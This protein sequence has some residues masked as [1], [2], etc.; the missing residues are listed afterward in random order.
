MIGSL[1]PVGAFN[2][3][4]FEPAVSRRAESSGQTEASTGAPAS[5][6]RN[7]KAQLSEA[8]QKRVR[9][10]Q[11]RDREVR[12]HEMAHV[13]AGGA[14]ILRGAQ[15][16]YETGPD[17][18]RYA[19]G[20]DVLI[21]TSPGRT[22]QETVEKAQRIIAAALAPADPSPQDR[23]VAAKATQMAAEARIEIVLQEREAATAPADGRD[24]VTDA[25]Q[26]PDPQP[27]SVFTGQQMTRAYNATGAADAAANLV[28]LFA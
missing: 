5:S 13:A 6:T 10:L 18:V 25:S 4:A 22:P 17:G 1:P 16:E 14:L 26:Q 24:A 2:P 20:G 15:Y 12:A 28:N 3:V 23:S 21:D 7:D 19:V 8:D 9:E 11:Q 27:T